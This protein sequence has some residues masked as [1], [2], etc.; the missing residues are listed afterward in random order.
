MGLPEKE[1][2]EFTDFGSLHKAYQKQVEYHITQLARQ[3]ELEY[4]IAGETAPYLFF[5]MLYDDCLAVGRGIFDGGVRYLG[6]TL[7]TYGN[8]NTADSLLAIKK[9]VFKEQ[10]C[11]LPELVAALDANFEGYENLRQICLNIPKYGNDHQEADAMLLDVDTHV[12]DFT[13][14]QHKVTGLHNYLVVIINNNANT[15]MGRYTC[16]SPD[17]RVAY[18]FMNNGNAPASGMDKSGVTAFLNSIVKPDPA[19][20]AGAVQNMKFTSEMFDIHRDKME[21]LLDTYFKNGGAQAMLNVLGRKDLENALEHPERY[22]N[23]IVRVGGFS[24]RFV[25]LE[26]DIQQEILARTLHS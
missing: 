24:A 14:N 3:E 7:E 19:L 9:V 21:F 1:L 17:G 20:H 8:S 4:K 18:S 15:V 2:G 11:S 6:G 22:Q 13:R 26:P 16:A 12:C 25:E 5:S 23:L 10:H